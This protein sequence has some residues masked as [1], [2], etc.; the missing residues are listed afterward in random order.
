MVRRTFAA[1]AALTLAATTGAV[2][3][4]TAGSSGDVA[5]QPATSAG[6]AIGTA[7]AAGPQIARAILK[8]AT[9]KKVGV[10][11]FRNVGKVTEVIA[12]FRK[13]A[14]VGAGFHGFHVHAN[15]L[16]DAGSGCVADAGGDPATW[17]LSAD[18]HLADEGETHGKHVGDMPSVYTLANGKARIAFQIDKIPFGRLVNSAVMLHAGP[19]NFANVPVGNGSD[20]YTEN[21]PAAGDKTMKTG[22]AGNRVACGVIKKL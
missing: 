15:N 20:Q 21:S 22:N 6:S 5:F 7:P 4:S 3:A 17:F 9:G 2:L 16:P 12:V 19:D 1:G 18:G 8:D 11:T 14:N 13:N 10:V